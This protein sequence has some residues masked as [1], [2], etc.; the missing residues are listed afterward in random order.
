MGFIQC[1]N[2]AM[3]Q[4][5]HNTVLVH[6]L[7]LSWLTKQRKSCPTGS[8]RLNKGRELLPLL[9]VLCSYFIKIEKFFSA[10]TQYQILCG[11]FFCQDLQ[12]GYNILRP[13]Q[14]QTGV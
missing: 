12:S 5:Q 10:E 2:C 1:E 8:K 9:C 6:N 13:R 14:A 7:N 3:A 11:V 4:R